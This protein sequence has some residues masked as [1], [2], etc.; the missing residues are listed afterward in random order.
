VTASKQRARP[1]Y[2]EAEMLRMLETRHTRDGNGGSGEF[3]FLTH[4]RDAA[5]FDGRRT[6]D[7]LALGLWKSRG[8]DL[9][10]FEVKCSRSDYLAELRNPAKAE[11]FGERV[12]Y[13]WMVVADPAIVKDDLPHGWGLLAATA[14]KVDEET[15]AKTLGTLRVVKQAPRQELTPE[16]RM[17]NRSWLVQMLRA[18][19]AVPGSRRESTPEEIQAAYQQGYK[20]AETAHDRNTANMRQRIATLEGQLAEMRNVQWTFEQ[21]AG[22]QLTGFRG[23]GLGRTEHIGNVVRAALRGD[24]AVQRAT[25]DMERAE[26]QLR[27]AADRL[28]DSREQN[29][30]AALPIKGVDDQ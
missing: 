26:K 5:G 7:A 2:T 6:I 19:G 1:L 18:A 21:H 25:H 30:G 24:E 29:L 9:H 11:V 20:A 27:D 22:I 16:Q 10:A 4:V 8:F 12:D 3:A 14:P 28:R 15:G 17:I 13:F 23:L